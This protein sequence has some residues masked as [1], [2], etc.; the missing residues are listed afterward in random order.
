VPAL[1]LQ[2]PAVL[3]RPLES[4]QLCG[5]QFF[6]DQVAFLE[7]V[8]FDDRGPDER[9]TPDV[10]RTPPKTPQDTRT[11]INGECRHDLDA[12]LAFLWVS[13]FRAFLLLM[14]ERT[15][16]EQVQKIKLDCSWLT[17]RALPRTRQRGAATKGL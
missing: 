1:V 11:G 2:P 7:Y 6:Q 4:G 5:K 10:G 13:G 12:A 9:H 17:A 15:V 16:V 8:H 3:V 14:D